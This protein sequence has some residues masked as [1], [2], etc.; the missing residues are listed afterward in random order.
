MVVTL[1]GKLGALAEEYA[2]QYLIR[3]KY[4]IVGRNYRKPWGEIDIVAEREG[5]VV[6]AEV[7][8]NRK[9]IAGFEPELRVDG[10]KR[11]RM[12]RIAQTFLTDHHF[13]ADQPW[14]MDVLAVTFVAERGVAKVRHYKN[15]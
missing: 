12:H 2:S 15:I 5:I 6:F 13:P 4:R 7:K 1:R 14:Q 11:H 8:A 9:E 10:G 3:K